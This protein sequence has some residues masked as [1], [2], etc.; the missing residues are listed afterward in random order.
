M[1]WSCIVLCCGVCRD[2]SSVF[3]PPIILPS[4]RDL[5]GTLEGQFE[6]LNDAG[7]D[8]HTSQYSSVCLCMNVCVCGR[9]R[10]CVCVC[11]R[12][13][14]GEREREKRERESVCVCMCVCVH[15]WMCVCMD[16]G[17][18]GPSPS[19]SSGSKGLFKL[20]WRRYIK[21]GNKFHM[22]ST[23]QLSFPQVALE[24]IIPLFF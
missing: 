17:V 18:R 16:A 8:A 3:S 15:A 24:Q 13:R 10:V 9:E 11:G 5:Q 12:E 2:W 6:D 14:E 21:V 7:L 19:C 23:P 22:H 1:G 20:T 4:D